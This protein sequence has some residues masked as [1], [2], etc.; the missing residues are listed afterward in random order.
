MNFNEVTSKNKNMFSKPVNNDHYDIAYELNES[1]DENAQSI[2]KKDDNAQIG[3][4]HNHN[5]DKLNQA[6]SDEEEEDDDDEDF[7][8]YKSKLKPGASADP[9]GSSNY[10][11]VPQFDIMEFR[12]LDVG[13][14]G[15]ELLSI[16]GK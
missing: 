11:K 6:K 9:T 2:G 12:N 14:D 7:A 16:M 5:I 1:A 15:M 4:H 10:T 13:Q 8:A 3:I